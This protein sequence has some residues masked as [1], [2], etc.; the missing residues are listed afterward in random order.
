MLNGKFAGPP[1][2]ERN[3]IYL[4]NNATTAVAP[5]VLEAMMPFLTELYG[6]P[7][8]AYEFGRTARAAVSEAREAVAGLLGADH[9]ENIVFTSGG[10]ESDNWAILGALEARPDLRGIVTTQVEHEAVRNLAN[11][12]EGEGF[13]VTCVP[14]GGDG[15]IDI[16][17]FTAAL[18]DETC[19][20][21]VMH[22]N[23]ETG[24]LFP[25]EELATIVKER[26]RALFHVDGINAAGK[27]PIDVKSTE[28]DLYSIS[29]HKFHAPKGV[30]AL[31]I[32]DGVELPARLIGGGQEAKRRAG[33]E[34]V[35]QVVGLGAAAEIVSDLSPMEKIRELRDRLESKILE[36]IPNSRLNGTCDPANRLPNT[37][38]ISFEHTNG[39]MVLAG[40]N[41]LGI[42]VSTGS[43]C[44]SADHAG[45]PV[46]QAMNVPY[47]F[48]MGSIRFSLGRNN[49]E[50]EIA[51]VVEVLP[52]I[53]ADLRKVAGIAA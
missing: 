7:S 34:A 39:E 14:V 52:G 53:I 30:G 36:I 8:S 45:S 5:Q 15:C 22:A 41:D 43:A 11:K 44:A 38:N 1:I 19:I 49:K 21:S 10:T 27:V 37:S 16:D 28:I 35:H 3:M 25:V 26:S 29:G 2:L 31:Y 42:C 33:T 24:V 40:L 51:S 23:N 32:R 47:S 12:L 13:S 46:L 6:N 4:D 48:A 18:T 20:V 17:E 50:A 9:P